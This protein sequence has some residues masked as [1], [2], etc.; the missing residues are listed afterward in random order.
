MFAPRSISLTAVQNHGQY[1]ATK[2][3]TLLLR[4]GA[5]R[6]SVPF[7]VIQK[8]LEPHPLLYAI[9]IFYCKSSPHSIN[10]YE[11]CHN[12]FSIKSSGEFPWKRGNVEEN[13]KKKTYRS[14]HTYFTPHVDESHCKGHVLFDTLHID[15]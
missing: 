5:R 15:P 8:R 4:G 1:L 7:K 3:S 13:P 11:D 14:Q 12:H 9:Q 10:H 6:F 2:A